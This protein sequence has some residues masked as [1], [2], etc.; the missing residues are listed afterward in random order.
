MES[1][2]GGYYRDEDL[3]SRYRQQKMAKS[4]FAKLHFRLI[5]KMRQA[6]HDF[7][8]LEDGDRIAVAVS[9]G[10]DSL[11][12]LRLLDWG[13]VGIPIRY[14]LVAVHVVSDFRCAGCCHSQVLKEIF[15]RDRYQYHFEPIKVVDGGKKVSCFWCSWN[16]R[17]ALFQV[18]DR[19]GCNK[20]AFGH[21]KDDIIQTTLLNLF[22]HGELSTMEPRVDLFQGRLAIIR[23]LTYIEEREII[24]YAKHCQF[25]QQFC[26]CPNSKTSK[27]KFTREII[28]QLEKDNKQI[29][30]NIFL[31]AIKG[32]LVRQHA[33]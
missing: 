25:P 22:Y 21:H 18:A 11:T 33:W 9:G 23:P 12:L 14:E 15:E 20:V 19:Y 10:K 31:C 16:R 28:T 32:R 2:G 4:S 24:S 6:S 26:C 8:L 7:G 5:R 30:N 27:R 3:L 1:G 17:K 13:R 29:K